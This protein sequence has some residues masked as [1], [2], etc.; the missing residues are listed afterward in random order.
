[1]SSSSDAGRWP[2]SAD[3]RQHAPGL[4]HDEHRVERAEPRTAVRLAHEQPRPARLARRRPQVGQRGRVLQRRPR[5]RHGRHP[6]E[7]VARRIAQERLLVGQLEV[8]DVA[9]A[10]S[11][12]RSSENG[13][14]LS[15]RGSGGSP[16]TRSP[17]V[18]R[19]IS[20]VP[21][22]DFRPGRNEVSSAHSLS[23]A[24]ASGPEHVGDEVAGLDRRAHRRDLREPRLGPRDLALLQRAQRPVARELHRQQLDAQLAEPAPH[25]RI[26]RARPRRRR[27]R[28]RSGR[29]GSPSPRTPARSSRART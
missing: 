27:S 9:A 28:A 15:S 22:A 14:P 20:S 24:S 23:S 12:A 10:R 18:L 13:M 25:L 19:R 3:A 5:G 16:S 17:T 29:R 21:P 7:R 26:A 1:M 4:A 11:F 2:S 8:H 6:R